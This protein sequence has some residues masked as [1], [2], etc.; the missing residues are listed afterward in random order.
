MIDRACLMKGRDHPAVGLAE[1]DIPGTDLRLRC[2]GYDEVEAVG[3]LL[4][5]DDGAREKAVFAIDLGTNVLAD[6]GP[7]DVASRDERR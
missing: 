3:E 1:G 5:D 2:R 7:P 6:R 4:E